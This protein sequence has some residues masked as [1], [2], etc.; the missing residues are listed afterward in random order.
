MPFK[1]RFIV[2]GQVAGKIYFHTG[3]RGLYG[4]HDSKQIEAADDYL[5]TVMTSN[6]HLLGGYTFVLGAL[7]GDEAGRDKVLDVFGFNVANEWPGNPEVDSWV[8]RD[9][10]FRRENPVSCLEG[11]RL[12]FGVEGE[13]QAGSN[14]LSDYLCMP[15]PKTRLILGGETRHITV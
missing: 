4:T 5:R 10:I 12:L 3:G 13:L 15:M 7:W 9:G 14:S 8:A 11:G 2:R 1:D 6:T